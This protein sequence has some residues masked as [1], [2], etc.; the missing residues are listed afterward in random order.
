LLSALNSMKRRRRSSV[1]YTPAAGQDHCWYADLP[2]VTTQCSLTVRNLGV[3]LDGQ[4]SMVD[5]VAAISRSCFAL[6]LRQFRAVR[7]SLTPEARWTLIQSFIS[8]R[9]DYCNGTLVGITDQLMQRLQ[10]VQNAAAR[11][12]VGARKFDPVSH[13]L[14]DL[15]SDNASPSSSAFWPTSTST[16]WPDHTCPKF[17][18]PTSSQASRPRLSSSSTNPHL[19]PRTCTCYGDRNIAVANQAAWNDL[20]AQ[21]MNPVCRCQLLGNCWKLYCS[22][23]G[24]ESLAH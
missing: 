15:Q 1:T 7:K 2:H 16:A 3:T 5:H 6:Q 24:T 4:L 11:L 13:I 18:V 9:L 17:H 14:C 23:M 10:A 19:V 20:P 21:L 8:N 12:I 22:I